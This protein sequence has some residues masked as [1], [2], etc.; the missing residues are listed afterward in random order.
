M[1]EAKRKTEG[2]PAAARRRLLEA[3][4]EQFN[5]RGYAATTV[6]EIVKAAGVTKPVLYYYFRSKEGIFLELMGETY[7]KFNELVESIR[8]ETGSAREKLERFIDLTFGLFL[9]EIKT[10]RL[11]YALYYGP[12][13]GAPFFDFDIY[14]RKYREA[15]RGVVEEGIR[16]GE[17][18]EESQE[19]MVWVIIGTINVAIEVELGHSDQSLGKEGLARLL[20][21]LFRGLGEPR[22][23]GG[24]KK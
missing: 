13:Q 17:F 22:K 3:A 7:R 1:Y 16:R 8:L 2:A 5:H 10:V 21:V 20:K 14:H 24:R 9:E 4:A 19:D 11:M 23:G 6:R 12:H 15:I 18:R